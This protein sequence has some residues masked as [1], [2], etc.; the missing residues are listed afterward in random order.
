L[1]DVY[2]IMAKSQST[3][4]GGGFTQGGSTFV[5]GLPIEVID[6][7]IAD[8]NAP[9]NVKQEAEK[10]KQEQIIKKEEEK[11][12]T[13]KGGGSSESK[14]SAQEAQQTELVK[15]AEKASDAAKGDEQAEIVI[16]VS[17]V[18]GLIGSGSSS[19]EAIKKAAKTTGLSEEKI[20][21][22]LNAKKGTGEVTGPTGPTDGTG[23][24][25]PT[26]SDTGP[27]GPT[28]GG[29]GGTGPTGGGTGGTGPT[30]SG[31]GG[32]SGTGGGSP[33]ITSGNLGIISPFLIQEY[34]GIQNLAPGLTTGGQYSLSGIPSTNTNMN[35]T[36]PNSPLQQFAPTS[37]ASPLMLGAPQQQP[38]GP[39]QMSTGGST[40]QK[41]YNPYDVSSGISGSLTP[42]LTKSKLD[43]LLTG[44][45]QNKAEGGHIEGHNPQF[46]SEGGLGSMD[47]TFVEGDGDG[48][49]DQVP[50]MLANGEFVIPA[51]VVSGLG[52]GSNDAGAEVLH[53][54]LK[55]IREHK[56][57]ANSDKLPPKSK[58]ALAYLTNAKRKVKV[59]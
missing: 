40:S 2:D 14:S 56:H 28:G 43:Y 44:L 1:P 29:T 46:F 33:S 26:G 50:A 21:D 42:G 3:T 31:G 9:Q 10:V 25:G 8:T 52:N 49:S 22:A 30:G 20:K 39:M 34:G 41:A 53:E 32:G 51:D 54:F 7:I 57:S 47:N 11:K 45:P 5:R 35:P 58:G 27:T 4:A 13:T 12:T 48:T 37:P 16:A 23:P 18:S 19:E 15:Q 24:T 6:A 36:T 59:A 55:V 17:L 38:Q